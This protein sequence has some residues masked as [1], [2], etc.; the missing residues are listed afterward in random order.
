MP[1]IGRTVLPDYPHHIVQRGHNRQVV[2]AEPRDFERYLQREKRGQ[3]T[4]STYIRPSLIALRQTTRKT[5]SPIVAAWQGRV[6]VQV[7]TLPR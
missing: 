3:R 6:F 4:I 5:G 2:F 7:Q 1:R